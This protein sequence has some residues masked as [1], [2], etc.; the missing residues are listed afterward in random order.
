MAGN[1]QPERLALPQVTLVAV[2]SVNI[3]ATMQ[4]IEACRMHVDFASCKLLTHLAP[5]KIPSGVDVVL[6]PQISSAQAYSQFMLGSLARHVD[7]SHCLVVQWDGHL[8]HPEFWNPQFLDYD[9]V[10]ASWPQ[11][12]DGYDV[13][14]G[15]FSLRSHRLIAACQAPHFTPSHPEDVA[16]G[17]INRPWLESQGM[18]FAPRELA[19]QFSAERA[20]APQDAFG[21]HGVWHMPSVLGVDEFWRA[22]QTLDDRTS[23]NQDL[24]QIMRQLMLHRGGF[25]RCLTLTTNRLRKAL[26]K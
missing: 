12:G 14:N 22:Y 26:W 4:A 13:G 10:G 24:G 23:V 16:I 18:R 3:T 15:G 11:F 25:R 1:A 17:R 19:D 21:Y 7:T 20:S 9:Y 2:T 6:V 8:I 5:P